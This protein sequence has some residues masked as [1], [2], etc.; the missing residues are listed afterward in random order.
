[1]KRFIKIR[2]T[3]IFCKIK[4]THDYPESYIKQSEKPSESINNPLPPNKI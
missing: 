1:M 4:D 2:Q 3:L